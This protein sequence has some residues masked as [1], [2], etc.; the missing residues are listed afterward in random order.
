M[1]ESIQYL[2]NILNSSDGDSL[3][4]PG[5]RYE[6]SDGEAPTSS[7]VS[8][9]LR[10]NPVF[11]AENL[12]EFTSLPFLSFDDDLA[13]QARRRQAMQDAQRMGSSSNGSSGGEV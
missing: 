10:N 11:L 4:F 12:H 6:T 5:H 2:K 13:T 7:P 1:W 9:V 8:E 3:V